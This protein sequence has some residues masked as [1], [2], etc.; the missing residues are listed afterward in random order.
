MSTISTIWIIVFAL[1]TLLFFGTAVVITIVGTRD[2]K[3]LL[4]KTETKSQADA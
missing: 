1:A 4:K 3:D 2:L